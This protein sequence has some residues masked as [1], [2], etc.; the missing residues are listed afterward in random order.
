[1]EDR[2][3]TYLYICPNC[4]KKREHTVPTDELLEFEGNNLCEMC[5]IHMVRERIVWYGSFQID[6]SEPYYNY[7]LGAK[8]TNK[9]DLQNAKAR[10]RG[11]HGVDVEEVGNESPKVE[12]PKKRVYPKGEEILA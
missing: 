6:T 1:M 8:I 9:R 10:V 4:S 5:H 3:L 12:P 7:G 11:E 2:G